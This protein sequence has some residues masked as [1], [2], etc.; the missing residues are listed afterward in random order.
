MERDILPSDPRNNGVKLPLTATELMKNRIEPKIY[1]NGKTSR[2]E[3]LDV[4]VGVIVNAARHRIDG[5]MSLDAA[6][7]NVTPYAV[8]VYIATKLILLDEDDRYNGPGRG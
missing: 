7:G 5:G 2:Q 6:I 8:D 4:I 3:V 1:T